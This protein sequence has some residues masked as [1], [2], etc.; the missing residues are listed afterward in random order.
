MTTKWSK[1]Q[2]DQKAHGGAATEGAQTSVTPDDGD[3]GDLKAEEM[4]DACVG[5]TPGAQNTP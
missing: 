5:G 2:E 3:G 4:V 1:F